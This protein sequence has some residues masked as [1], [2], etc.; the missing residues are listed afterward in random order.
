MSK[1]LQSYPFIPF[2]TNVVSPQTVQVPRLLDEGETVDVTYLD[3][4]KTYGPV[5][6]STV[7]TK[8]MRCGL[9]KWVGEKLAGLLERL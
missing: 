7:K 6:C 1:R 3:F 5:C 4:S 2:F 8:L 9:G